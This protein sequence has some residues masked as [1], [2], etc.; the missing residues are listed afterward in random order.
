MSI[1]ALN[2][3]P[4][5]ISSI[6]QQ[7]FYSSLYSFVRCIPNIIDCKILLFPLK[8][9]PKML[10]VKSISQIDKLYCESAYLLD[11]TYDEISNI[12]DYQYLTIDVKAIRDQ[13]GHRYYEQFYQQT[14]WRKEIVLLIKIDKNNIICIAINSIASYQSFSDY[15]SIIREAIIKHES[16]QVTEYLHLENQHIV[17][18]SIQKQDH[19]NLTNREKQITS[20]ILQGYSQ[21]KIAEKCF[22]SEGTVKNHKKKIYKKLDIHS[23]SEFFIKLNQFTHIDL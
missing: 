15:F 8:K 10:G 9:K 6:G 7:H 20:L 12:I 19:H 17:G 16:R 18:N 21:S 1:T 5:L 4:Q 14:N 2:S 3:I 11:P 22:I 13:R 23:Q